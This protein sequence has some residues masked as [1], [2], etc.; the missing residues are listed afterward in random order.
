MTGYYDYVL[1]LIP[2]ALGGVTAFLYLLGIPLTTAVFVGA[3][4]ASLPM[5]HALF[6]RNPVREVRASDADAHAEVG[7]GESRTAGDDG[8]FGGRRSGGAP[9]E[10]AD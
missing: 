5:C 8:G 10:R 2:T 7:V 4:L 1:G 6:V 9:P 3:G